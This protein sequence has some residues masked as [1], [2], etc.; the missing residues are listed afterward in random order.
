MNLVLRQEDSEGHFAVVAITPMLDL[1]DV[2]TTSFLCLYNFDLFSST[3]ILKFINLNDTTQAGTLVHRVDKF[4]DLIETIEVVG[5]IL[6]DWQLTKHHFVD[7]LGHIL[8][9]F[10]ST[11]GCSLP[12][13]SSDELEWSGFTGLT[14]S[15]DSNDRRFT[16]TTMSSFQGISHHAD[17]TR[18]IESEV[19]T[20]LLALLQPF[21]SILRHGV[22]AVRGTKLFCN[23]E[24]TLVD[25]Q[26][27]DPVSTSIFGSLNDR[28]TYS[29]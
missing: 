22:V 2:A 1:F 8:S 19:D 6:V 24:F 28:E 13:A 17:I 7:K 14:G 20:P 16:P 15:G 11:E 29:A 9:R 26:G 18:A 21:T 23:L 12:L 10:P 4:V 25:I 5:D 27:V 3:C